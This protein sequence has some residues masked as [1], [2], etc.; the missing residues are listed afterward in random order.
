VGTGLASA[1]EASEG[2]MMT[3]GYRPQG[4]PLSLKPVAG[5]R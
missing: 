1:P 5:R 4:F 2:E 3:A